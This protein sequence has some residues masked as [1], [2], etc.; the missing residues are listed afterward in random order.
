[1]QNFIS[2]LVG[3]LFALGLG[4]SGMTKTPLVQGFLDF[5]GEWKG[6]LVGVMGGAIFVHMVSYF[7]IKKKA[8][9]L[10]AKSF[11]L[12]TKKDLDKRLIGGAV[13][14]G[15]G[16]GYAGLCPG[17]AIVSLPTGRMEIIIFVFSMFVGMKTLKIIQK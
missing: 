10:F 14:F 7:F 13:I 9:P 12:P 4:I 15:I 5:F 6:T 2:L 11:Q 1:M 8:S 17:P 3:F 16:W